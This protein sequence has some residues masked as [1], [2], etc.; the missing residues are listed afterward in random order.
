MSATP[1][2]GEEERGKR[3][4]LLILAGCLGALL[5]GVLVL[6]TSRAAFS[7]QTDNTTNSVGAGDV[8]LTDDDSG[9]AMFTISNM[10]PDDAAVVECIEVTYSGTIADPGDVRLFSGGFTDSG[11]LADELDITVEVGTGGSFGDCTGFSSASTIF[12]TDTLTAFDT[13]H[14][15]YASGAVGW[16]PSSTPESRT[17]R[18]TVDLP[19]SASSSVQGDSVTDLTFTW[20]AQ[21]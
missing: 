8:T 20:E 11:S 15:D 7:A 13:A 6:T 14:S 17:F 16:N 9:S 3:R 4:G 12:T 2:I 10:A 5:S 1:R 18:F 21:S 19:T